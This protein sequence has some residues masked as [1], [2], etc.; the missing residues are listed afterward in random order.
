MI[1]LLFSDFDDERIQLQ[2]MNF[3]MGFIQTIFLILEGY[4]QNPNDLHVLEPEEYL[5]DSFDNSEIFRES[6]GSG[7]GLEPW[8][9]SGGPIKKVKKEEREEA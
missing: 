7:V 8:N 6:W 3:F 2:F 9:V 5:H 1:K 4:F